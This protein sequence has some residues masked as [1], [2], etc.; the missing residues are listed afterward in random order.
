M[1]TSE[2]DYGTLKP[3]FSKGLLP[4]ILQHHETGRVLMLGYMNEEAFALTKRDGRAWFYSRSRDRLWLKGESSEHYQDVVDMQLDCDSDA[5]LLMVNPSG[6][7]CHLGT[8]SCFD[9]VH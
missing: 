6:P 3:D 9:T 4:V 1:S 2:N 5:L 8:P 7:T